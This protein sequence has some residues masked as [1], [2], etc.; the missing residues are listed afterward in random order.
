MQK[1]EQ[2]VVKRLKLINAMNTTIEMDSNSSKHA[3]FMKEA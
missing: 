2:D 1:S 3:S